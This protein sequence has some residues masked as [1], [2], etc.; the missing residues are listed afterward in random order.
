MLPWEHI[1]ELFQ[2]KP[3]NELTKYRKDDL[4]AAPD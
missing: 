2:I 1:R 4:S 3:E